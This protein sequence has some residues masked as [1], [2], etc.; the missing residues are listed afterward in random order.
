MAFW[1][2]NKIYAGNTAGTPFV[3]DDA[4]T[5]NNVIPPTKGFGFKYAATVV[6]AVLNRSKW[7]STT[8]YQILKACL[9]KDEDRSLSG[10]VGG[11]SESAIS[12]YVAPDQI[13][14][15]TV[16]TNDFTIAAGTGALVN[17]QNVLTITSA[18]TG[19]NKTFSFKLHVDFVAWLKGRTAPVNS[20]ITKDTFTVNNSGAVGTPLIVSVTDLVYINTVSIKTF[21]ISFKGTVKVFSN[22]TH[23]AIY[24]LQL[25]NVTTNTILDTV[26]V[27]FKT[28][29]L[30][31]RLILPVSLNTISTLNINDILI[32]RL[33]IQWDEDSFTDIILTNSTLTFLE[34]KS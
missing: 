31:D 9:H 19:T 25:F 8:F 21:L 24:N 23:S 29:T 18:S 33:N 2:R 15:N 5:N 16:T 14:T 30:N 4:V 6:D 22:P 20:L 13:P 28:I 17:N 3:D 10:D 12:R 32:V 11:S 1:S 34:I 27:E 26:A 7:L